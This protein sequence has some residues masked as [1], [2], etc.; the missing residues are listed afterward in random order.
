MAVPYLLPYMCPHC[1][2]FAGSGHKM[3]C[4]TEEDVVIQP[5][6]QMDLSWVD[7]CLRGID[8]DE[9]E[10]EDGWWE[11]SEGAEFGRE[12]L[13]ALKTEIERRYG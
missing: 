3:T 6:V 2:R 5:S 8:Q 1:Q 12:R 13:A 11:T 9:C 7:D 10:H 4:P